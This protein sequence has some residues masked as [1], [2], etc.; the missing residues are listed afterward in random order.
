MNG[1]ERM[2]R[3]QWL[4]RR[5]MKEL[6]ILLLGFLEQNRSAL[7]RGDWPELE[8]LLGWEDDVL[9]DA[10]QNPAT[11]PVPDTQALLLTIRGSRD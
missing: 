5:G 11:V 10:V 1:T 9:W 7:A 6:D 8:M 4:C 3:L 2:R